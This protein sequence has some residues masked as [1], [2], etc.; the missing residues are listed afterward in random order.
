MDVA[1][2]VCGITNRQDAERALDL[3]AEYL[4]I[5]VYEKSPRAVA[6]GEIP[7][8]LRY[9]PRGKRV[10][11]DVSTATDVL[12]QYKELPFDAYQIHFD[13]EVAIATVAAWAGLVGTERLW[14]APRIPNDEAYFPQ[15]T[16]EFADTIVI[17]A[18][19]K[20]AYGGTG[21]VADWQRFL[22]WSMLYQHKRWIL[23]GGLN[24]DNIGAALRATQA[25]FVDVNSGVERAPGEKDPEKLAA[26][27][28]AVREAA[29][30]LPQ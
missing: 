19:S 11:V 20:S 24:P 13:L 10:L 9:I 30:E 1:V 22:D 26:F 18:Y 28:R 5:I 7:N 29:S 16:M 21:H 25:E 4:G 3:G 12:D 17:D 23:A 15:I 27:F 8:L 14:L 6:V 2:K